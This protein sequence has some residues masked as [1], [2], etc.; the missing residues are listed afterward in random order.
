VLHFFSLLFY[1][2]YQPQPH[3][4]QV[5]HQRQGLRRDPGTAERALLGGHVGDAVPAQLHPPAGQRPSLPEACCER[6]QVL[7]QGTIAQHQP[8]LA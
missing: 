7:H 6:V 3:P 5:L 1:F 8:A 4:I 2:L